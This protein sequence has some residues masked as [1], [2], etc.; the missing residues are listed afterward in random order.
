VR[1]F[2]CLCHDKMVE[3]II[4]M[5]K[6]VDLSKM[7]LS[8]IHFAPT[9]WMSKKYSKYMIFY[10]YLLEIMYINFNGIYLLL[11]CRRI[12]FEWEGFSLEPFRNYNR[13]L[14][15][16]KDSR[17]NS[18]HSNTTLDIYMQ[19]PFILSWSTLFHVIKNQKSCILNTFCPSSSR[20]KT[21][22]RNSELVSLTV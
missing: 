10:F 1:V 17:P 9:W 6:D 15:F 8:A 3:S 18:S 14:S 5:S 19:I 13:L 2:K 7:L 11:E 12:V 22:G 16:C 21:N 20:H 4:C